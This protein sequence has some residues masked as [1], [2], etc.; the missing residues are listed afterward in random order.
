MK[1]TDLRKISIRKQV[2]I[3]FG[4][5]NGSECIVDEHGNAR[6]PGLNGVPGYNLD[7]ILASVASFR[8]ETADAPAA[9]KSQAA[10]IADLEKMLAAVSPAGAAAAAHDHEE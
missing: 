6:V 7:E 1:L 5:P 9:G 10:S 2:R 3:K 8:V 4:L